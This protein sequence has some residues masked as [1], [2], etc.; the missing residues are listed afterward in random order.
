METSKRKLVIHM[1]MNLTCIMQDVANQYTIEI[2][3]SKI[4]ASQCWGNIIYKDSVPSWKLAH[5][6]ISFLQPA[7]EL[8]SYDEFIKNLYKK[9][10]PTEEPDETKRQLYNNEQRTVYLKII[11]E[12]TQPGKPGYKFKSLFDK[13]IRLLSLPKPICEEYNLVPE[14]EKKEEIG[15]DEDEKELIKRIFASGK[16]MLIPSF[17]RLIQELK[18]NKREFAIIFRTFGEELDKVIDEFNL[19][20]RGNHPL[21]NGKHGTPRIR[22][23]GKSKSK[24]MLI[25]YHN[26]GYMTRVPSETSFVVGTLKRHPAS[27]SIEEAHSGGIEEGVIVVHQDFPSIYVAIQERLYKAASM[28]ISDDYRYWNQNGETGEYGK[29]LLIDENDYQIQHIFFDDNI[30]IENPKIVDVRDVVTGEPIPFK[31]SINKYIFRVDSYRAI[32]EQDYFYKSVLACEENRSEEIYR[33]ENGITEEKEEQVDVQVSEWEKLQSSPTDEY[34]ARVIMP[35]LLPALQVLDIER[36]QN[37]ISFLAH[38]V[39]KHQDRVV[40][41]SRS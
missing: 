22:F 3:I 40:L 24:D 26:F 14:D 12:F 15:D 2:T 34:L 21:F 10:L 11:S 38:Y 28:A 35:V 18:K 30:D 19:F 39:L 4:L 29:L 27:E 41:P 5:P 32:V 31:R 1:D 7:P 33:I 16:M 6:T 25:D 9:K 23:D 13:M 8:T 37:P 20:C 17:F 36:P